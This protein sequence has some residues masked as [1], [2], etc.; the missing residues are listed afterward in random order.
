MKT[1]LWKCNTFVARSQKFEN[2]GDFD[3]LMSDLGVHWTIVF[4]FSLL[5]F[6]RLC[7]LNYW[8][9]LFRKKCWNSGNS[10][11]LVYV[12]V[13]WTTIVKISETLKIEVQQRE[14]AWRHLAD[15]LNSE[16]CRSVKRFSW[17]SDW[18]Q[19]VQTCV[20]IVDLVK[21]IHTNIY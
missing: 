12:Q 21:R 11:T 1:R 3:L 14:N 5:S 4:S 17:F 15:F 13:C 6:P 8:L 16:R 18:N 2:L 19:K 10:S 20:N 7:A 9:I